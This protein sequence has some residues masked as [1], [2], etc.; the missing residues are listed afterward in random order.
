[1]NSFLL[2]GQ[3]NMAGRGFID[4]AIPTDL[5]ALYTLRNGRWMKM[6]R[7]IN[8]D[9]SRSGVSLG[10]RFAECFHNEYG[11]DIGLICCADGG[12]K[13][14]QWSTDGVL[15]QNALN[16]AR[17]AMRSSKLLGILWHQG[18]SDCSPE[19]S[20]GYKQKLIAMLS[21][22][23]RDLGDD[24]LPIIIGGLGDY[25]VNYKKDADTGKYY[26]VIN[27]A[28]SEVA[29]TLPNCAFVCATGLTSNPDN[30]HFN[31]ASLYTFG[32]RYFEKYKALAR[33]IV[34]DG[35]HS[36]TKL[37]DIEKL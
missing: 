6:F 5:S 28:L 31:S 22:F 23:R 24:S 1:M 14:D 8:P 34:K 10:E 3:S 29:D 35:T 15:Y 36:V 13:I 21:A 12:T 33:D 16:N 2:I 18:E 11:A 9:R 30:L 7:P 20:K 25:L 19:L 37:S 17:L 26:T 27:E 4:D 32:E